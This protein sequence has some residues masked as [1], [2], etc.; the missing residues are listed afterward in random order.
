MCCYYFRAL[1][2]PQHTYLKSSLPCDNRVHSVQYLKINTFLPLIMNVLIQKT[3][4]G[5]VNW[6]GCGQSTS[7]GAYHHWRL[8]L[9]DYELASL[10]SDRSKSNWQLQFANGK[11]YG[12]FSWL[13]LDRSYFKCLR[14][15][16][17][18]GWSFVGN[19]SKRNASGK[20][21]LRRTSTKID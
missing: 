5:D 3:T 17:I 9:F 4:T 7:L 11:F 2:K 14:E 19:Y 16:E 13:I 10:Y 21:Q 6:K 12:T 20:S 18:V 15:K 8:W 1:S